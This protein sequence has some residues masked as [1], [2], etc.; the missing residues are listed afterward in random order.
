MLM[1]FYRP[2]RK[3]ISIRKLTAITAYGIGLGG[4]NFFF[5][6]ALQTI[7]FGIAVAIGFSG[8]LAIALISARRPLD[9]VCV[10]IALTG[11][12]L[13]MPIWEGGEKLDVMG[14]L[15]AVTSACFWAMYI[16]FGKKTEG[17]SFGTSVSL[18]LFF[19]SIFVVPVGFL[20]VGTALFEPYVLFVGLVVA[21]LSSAIPISL[22][23]I[24]L[25]G[26]PQQTFGIMVSLEP[27]IAS[28]VAMIFLNE[29]INLIQCIAIGLIMLAS[30]GSA[31]MA[32]RR[33]N[34]N[35]LTGCKIN[36]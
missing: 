19:A 17:V 14:V 15:F 5:Y 29:Y 12:L 35:E 11:L 13:L 10:I 31:F 21:V 27:A 7:P 20:H 9:F 6:L 24:A 36:S 4:M 33:G 26:L 25:Q 23:M 28:V 18:G 34:E 30:M 22:E 16:F 3:S 1:I 8:P 2:W 32:S